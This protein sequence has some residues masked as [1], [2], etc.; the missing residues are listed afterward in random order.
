MV[1]DGHYWVVRDGKIIDPMF[2]SYEEV[3]SIC[4]LKGDP[5]YLPADDLTQQVFKK[6]LSIK[7]NKLEERGLHFLGRKGDWKITDGCC[8]MNAYTEQKLRGGEI[9]FGSM[10]WKR[11]NGNGIHYEFGGEGWTVSK[12]MKK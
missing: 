3:K 4:G 5:I 8:D 9:I 11:I 12:F 2:K 10:G 1:F 6:K 7:I